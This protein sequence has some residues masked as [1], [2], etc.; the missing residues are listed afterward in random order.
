[1]SCTLNGVPIR[2][3]PMINEAGPIGSPPRRHAEEFVWHMKSRLGGED[4]RYFVELLCGCRWH[5][6]PQEEPRIALRTE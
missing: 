6:M 2:L 3:L 4:F 5:N 1:M